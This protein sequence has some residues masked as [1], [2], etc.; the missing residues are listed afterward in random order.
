MFALSRSKK[1]LY[2]ERDTMTEYKKATLDDIIADAKANERVDYLKS[3]AKKTVKTPEGKRK[4]S[5]MEL[6]RQ[7]F[8]TYYPNDVPK[9]KEKAVSMWDKIE[10]L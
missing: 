7:Y 8:M 6:K 1:A 4:I 2:A 9:A 10:N 3:L 5:F